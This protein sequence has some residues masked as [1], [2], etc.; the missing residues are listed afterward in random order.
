[1]FGYSSSNLKEWVEEKTSG[2]IKSDQVR[3]V[4]LADLRSGNS[5]HI[6]DTL[7]KLR[8]GEYCIVNCAAYQDL[9]IFCRCYWE[10]FDRQKEILFRSAASLISSLIDQPHGRFLQRADLNLNK[11]SKG[12]VVVGSHVAKT[13]DQLNL[14][15]AEYTGSAVEIHVQSLLQDHAE[16]EISRVVS[17][18][19]RLLQKGKTPIVYTSRE[20]IALE[21]GEDNQ[22]IGEQISAGLVEIVK[23]A[24]EPDFIIAKGGITSSDIATDA[25]NVK[26][27]M[28]IGQ[29][30]PGISIWKLGKGSRYP[31]LPFVVFPGNVG[32]ESD[33]LRVYI[34][35]I[36]KE[37]RNETI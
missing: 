10:V 17:C 29:I 9:D 21:Q 12:L 31:D 30:L 34:E 26:K 16:D 24:Q 22:Q 15:L 4:S 14:L 28:V 7:M 1:M 19:D 32:K 18:I 37:G 13:T 2:K 5:Q 25:L 27:A 36:G 11:N 35:L 23:R 8:K 20:L 3:A 6:I 33:L